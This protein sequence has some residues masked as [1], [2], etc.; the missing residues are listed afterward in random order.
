LIIIN[1]FW[2]FKNKNNGS[3]ENTERELYLEGPIGNETWWGDEVTPKEFKSELN[4][5][6]GDITVYI[7]SPGGDVFAA[8]A[9]YSAL[10]KPGQGNGENLCSGS[11]SGKYCGDGGR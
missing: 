1:R 6:K 2:S 7:D 10:K 3:K 9:I 8:S 5:G 11:F 4:S